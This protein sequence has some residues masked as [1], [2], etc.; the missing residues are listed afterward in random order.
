M[1]SR[2]ERLKLQSEAVEY[3]VGHGLTMTENAT[4]V[5]AKYDELLEEAG[6][7][8]PDQP[9][10]PVISTEPCSCKQGD[11]LIAPDETAAPDFA[12]NEAES[13]KASATLQDSCN[14]PDNQI[15]EW[16]TVDNPLDDKWINAPDE[17]AAVLWP[18]RLPEHIVRRALS[19][20]FSE[21]I[22]DGVVTHLGQATP[23]PTPPADTRPTRSELY[24]IWHV[25]FSVEAEYSAL[26]STKAYAD[27]MIAA[28]IARE[29]DPAPVEPSDEE[30][31]E[32][33]AAMGW[34]DPGPF[35]RK[36]AKCALIA[37]YRKVR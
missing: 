33:C 37:G 7:F 32:M 14:A 10:A 34:P 35:A 3:W 36:S 31:R 6:A 28:G 13:L 25:G 15:R 29:D 22:V 9:A 17:D 1:L 18:N 5:A 16:L 20:Y 12:R 26:T 2:D 24:A 23:D 8:T 21:W 30:I 11:A 27:A 4:K 19:P